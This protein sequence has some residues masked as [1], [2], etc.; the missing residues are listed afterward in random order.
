M[1]KCFYG[2]LL[3]AI[4][5][6]SSTGCTNST[7]TEVA[8]NINVNYVSDSVRLIEMNLFEARSKI[9]NS[10]NRFYVNYSDT[11]NG[12]SIST[13]CIK[14]SHLNDG[15]WIAIFKFKH[16]AGF[17]F[18]LIDSSYNVYQLFEKEGVTKLSNDTLISI[19]YPNAKGLD[20]LRVDVPFFFSDVNFDQK[21]ELI[22][23]IHGKAQRGGDAYQVYALKDNGELQAKY[24]QITSQKPFVDFNSSTS[25]NL[26]EKSVT[27][28]FSGGAGDSNFETFSIDE[29]KSV[30]KINRYAL[31][32][33]D[34]W[35]NGVHRTSYSKKD[36]STSSLNY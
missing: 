19:N 28:V 16:Q 7:K 31:K 36:L 21:N 12:Y 29:K 17:S 2:F 4:I 5:T 25:F 18:T 35:E 23:N 34:I 14:D 10:L 22:L 11:I 33:I 32:K 20:T 6:L 24:L 9:I 1:R 30:S 27:T 3:H 26:K 8:E 13:E 15:T